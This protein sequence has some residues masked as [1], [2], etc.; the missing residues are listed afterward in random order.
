MR[1]RIAA[2]EY[3]SLF[4]R[5]A[6]ARYACTTNGSGQPP[7]RLLFSFLA[8][9]K[10]TSARN[11]CHRAAGCRASI[12]ASRRG[13]RE[14][15]LIRI[16]IPSLNSPVATLP[17]RCFSFVSLREDWLGMVK[18]TAR[19]P[20]GVPHIR[21]SAAT[22][23]CGHLTQGRQNSRQSGPPCSTV[24]LLQPRTIVS[25]GARKLLGWWK[26]NPMWRYLS[27]VCVERFPAPRRRFRSFFSRG[28]HAF[29]HSL[30]SEKGRHLPQ[31]GIFCGFDGA[32][33]TS[34]FTTIRRHYSH[35]FLQLGRKNHVGI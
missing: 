11:V 8:N 30:K 6:V 9:L 28:C 33:F 4:P 32:G 15:Q 2:L 12:R 22:R 10:P 21:P 34:G 35:S 26:G 27:V 13:Q 17:R 1:S 7:S 29:G 3:G 20:A 14:P 24:D 25:N 16:S 19:I 5:Q 31:Q 18:L 23:R